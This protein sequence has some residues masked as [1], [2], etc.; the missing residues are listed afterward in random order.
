MRQVIRT[1]IILRLLQ[2]SFQSKF[3]ELFQL[4]SNLVTRCHVTYQS[5]FFFEAIV[6]DFE[7][8]KIIIELLKDYHSEIIFSRIQAPDES[9]SGRHHESARTNLVPVADVCQSGSQA[10]YELN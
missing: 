4:E 5:Y 3:E 1:N 2:I 9:F 8:C 6:L 10:Y 7:R